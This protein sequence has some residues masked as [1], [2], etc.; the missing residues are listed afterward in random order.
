MTRGTGP[1]TGRGDGVPRAAGGLGDADRAPPA[2]L[3]RREDPSLRWVSGAPS[4]ES[5]RLAAPILSRAP[6]ETSA[7]ASG[8]TNEE[9]EASARAASRFARAS[10]TLVR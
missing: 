2:R 3:L 6:A 5:R 8:E 10:S 9:P 1:P 4:R 7:L